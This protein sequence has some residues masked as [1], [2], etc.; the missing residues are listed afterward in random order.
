MFSYEL[1]RLIAEEREREV[2]AS[3]RL[4]RMLE[5]RDHA[6]TEP[7]SCEEQD[8]RYPDAWR[9]RAPRANATTR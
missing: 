4:R 7:G 3:M 2:Q 9:A 6:T 8:G 1:M 5:P